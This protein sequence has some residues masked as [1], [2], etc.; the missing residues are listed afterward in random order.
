M[1]PMQAYQSMNEQLLTGC[2]CHTWFGSQGGYQFLT[3]IHA[4]NNNKKLLWL[5]GAAQESHLYQQ[6]WI[7]FNVQLV[8]SSSEGVMKIML[9]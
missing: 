8:M 6:Q 9:V 4:Y 7:S 5:S 2:H 3:S 1:G